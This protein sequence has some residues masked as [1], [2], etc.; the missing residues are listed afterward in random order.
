M[1]SFA[2]FAAGIFI[3]SVGAI[4]VAQPTPTEFSR[5]LHKLIDTAKDGFKPI[6]GEVLNRDKNANPNSWRSTVQLPGAQETTIHAAQYGQ[7][8]SVGATIF[9]SKDSQKIR[10]AYQES[11]QRVRASLPASSWTVVESTPPIRAES[12]VSRFT[13]RG[14]EWPRV[15]VFYRTGADG[16]HV[17]LR[18]DG[19]KE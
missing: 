5:A 8:I 12:K 7:P 3:L 14:S 10:S 18:V 2:K 4:A 16:G 17:A 11:V 1:L 6:R 19:P 9:E 13:Y 15:V